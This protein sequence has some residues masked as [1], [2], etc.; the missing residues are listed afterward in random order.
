MLGEVVTFY[1]TM[2]SEFLI[3]VVPLL[4]DLG[5]LQKNN[6]FVGCVCYWGEF[7]EDASDIVD[8]WRII[9]FVVFEC[10]VG[11]AAGVWRRL[12]R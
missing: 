6:E 4:F 8:S 11:A 5:N 2:V 9:G 12:E 7:I 10:A 1:L 3:V